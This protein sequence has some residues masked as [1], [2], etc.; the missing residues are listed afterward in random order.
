MAPHRRKTQKRLAA[1]PAKPSVSAMV[2]LTCGPNSRVTGLST[3][4]GNRN[5][6]FHITLMPCGVFIAVVTRAGRCPCATA[7]AAYRMNQTNR[8]TSSGSPTCTRDAGSA[9]SRQ[10]STTAPAR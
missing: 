7:V 5:D 1:E 10:V 9:H 3:T 8:S 4:P 2:R 6:V